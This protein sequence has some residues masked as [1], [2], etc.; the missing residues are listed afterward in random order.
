[1]DRFLLKRFAQPREIG[2]RA[3]ASSK[4]LIGL[5]IDGLGAS[6]IGFD[7]EAHCLAL[8]EPR[9]AGLLDRGDMNKHIF[10]TV[11]GGNETEA[12]SRI[13]KFYS[14]FSHYFAFI[15]K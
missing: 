5:Q 8:I 1:M 4:A 11:F 12:T 10:R 3:N 2:V 9:Q 7:V 6:R 15:I 13:K 14:T